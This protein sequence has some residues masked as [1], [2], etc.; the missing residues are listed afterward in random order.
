M[1]RINLLP[2]EERFETKIPWKNYA[3][4]AI[5]LCVVMLVLTITQKRAIKF[6]ETSIEMKNE[7]HA[8]LSAQQIEQ[9]LKL[10]NLNQ[11]K[12]E[13]KKDKE[14]VQKKINLLLSSRPQGYPLTE[15]FIQLGRLLPENIW[16]EEFDFQEDKIVIKGYTQENG[17]ISNLMKNLDESK[18]FENTQFDYMQIDQ[19]EDNAMMLFS[20]TTSLNNRD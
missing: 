17:L 15:V 8:I 18:Y 19:K 6:Y 4:T 5:V 2:R 7:D 14:L 13:L 1:Q 20:V 11:K 16:L 9:K 12:E 10:D 3:Y